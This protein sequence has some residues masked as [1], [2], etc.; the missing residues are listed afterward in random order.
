MGDYYIAADLI[1]PWFLEKNGGRSHALTPFSTRVASGLW[2]RHYL[3]ELTD[4]RH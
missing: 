4:P 3:I 2:P 1:Q